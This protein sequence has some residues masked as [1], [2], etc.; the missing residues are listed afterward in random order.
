MIDKEIREMKKGTLLTHVAMIGL[1][2]TGVGATQAAMQPEDP[3]GDAV[4]IAQTEEP[5]EG[6]A[7]NRLTLAEVVDIKYPV[8]LISEVVADGSNVVSQSAVVGDHIIVKLQEGKVQADLETLNAQLGGTIRRTL[9]TPRTYLVS[10]TNA[11]LY[12]VDNAV[13]AYSADTNIVLYAEPDGLMHLNSFTPNDSSFTNLWGLHNT[14]QSGGTSDMDI[15]APEAWDTTRGTGVV[16]AVLDSGV[17]YTHPDLAANMW[18]NV[19]EIAGNGIDDDGNGFTNDVYGYDF[20]NNDSN[21]MDDNNHGTHCAGIIAA[22]GNNS[23]G[24]VGVAWQS[25]IMALKL[26]SAGGGNTAAGLISD[27]VDSLEYVMVMKQRGVNVRIASVSLGGA[28][29]SSVLRDRIQAAATNGILMVAAAGNDYKNFEDVGYVFVRNYPACYESDNVISVAAMDRN[30]NM[31]L[32]SN[33]GSVDVDLSAP[34]VSILSTIRNNGFDTWDGT[35][36]ATPYVAGVAA[37]LFSHDPALSIGRARRILLD[38]T[39]PMLTPTDGWTA[40][41]GCVNAARAL[42]MLDAVS[43]PTFDPTPG[44]FD[45]NTV[46]VTMASETPGAAIYFTTNGVDPDTTSILY[47]APVTIAMGTTLKARAY[48]SGMPESPLEA[49]GYSWSRRRALRWGLSLNPGWTTNGL[50]AYGVPTGAGYGDPTSGATGTNVYGYNLNGNYEQGI[51]RYLTTPAIDC[52]SLTATQLRFKRKLFLADGDSS[53][54]ISTNGTTWLDVW[55]IT[56]DARFV[57][58]ASVEV[59]DI[60][61][62][63][64]VHDISKVADGQPTIY[65]RWVMG[66]IESN[67]ITRGGWNIDDVEIWSSKNPATI[68]HSEPSWAF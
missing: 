30:G 21:P 19:N 27:M 11:T 13:A 45:T 57:S 52:S 35:S 32:F 61:W 26:A 16:V 39:S 54:Q 66:P 1:F 59:R 14:G 7:T 67:G 41:D 17:D 42:E 46:Q 47:T 31:P 53:I 4:V 36:M 55:K 37:L 29:A 20:Y 49:G 38:S 9:Y 33:R 3:Y 44:F 23:T 60:S 24:V 50:W 63:P 43:A 5:G 65:L 8:L 40:T 62:Q 56:A 28:N 51:T 25:K 15:D 68:I 64:I 48:A 6:G 12:T 58:S 18:S 22:S 34:G 2:L 10:F